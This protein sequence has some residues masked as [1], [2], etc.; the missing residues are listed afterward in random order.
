MIKEKSTSAVPW[1]G[2]TPDDQIRKMSLV[3]FECW[4]GCF[5]CKHSSESSIMLHLKIMRGFKGFFFLQFRGEYGRKN[6]WSAE[7]EITDTRKATSKWP[8]ESCFPPVEKKYLR[9]WKWI[10]FV[11]FNMG[12]KLSRRKSQNLYT[13]QKKTTPNPIKKN[14]KEN[15]NHEKP[16]EAKTKTTQP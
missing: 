1:W 7:G 3:R 15:L 13:K 10:N 8:L 6:P 12:R 2:P 14:N 4:F 16:N 5:F 9:M 11:I